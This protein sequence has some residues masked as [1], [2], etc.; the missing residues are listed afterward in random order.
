[1][2]KIFLALNLILFHLIPS[3]CQDYSC[4]NNIDTLNKYDENG[5]KTG[6]WSEFL[7]KKFRPT[8]KENKAVFLW[9]IFY[10]NGERT[11][12]KLVLNPIIGKTCL[13]IE[14]NEPQNERIILLDGNYSLYLYREKK[15]RLF[16]QF[17]FEKGHLLSTTSIYKNGQINECINFENKHMLYP[18]SCFCTS[19]NEKGEVEM[20]SYWV[21]ENSR[22]KPIEMVDR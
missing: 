2:K 15:N 19:Y 9:Y 11:S 17:E 4:I 13:K 5:K 18:F 3:I 14:G 12:I 16:K 8:R 21:F 1:M 10:Q 20:K 22:W 6:Y 7:N